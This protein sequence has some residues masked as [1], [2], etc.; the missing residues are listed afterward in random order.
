MEGI[1]E[2]GGWGDGGGIHSATVWEKWGGREIIACL[3]AAI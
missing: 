2:K 3:R 1:N